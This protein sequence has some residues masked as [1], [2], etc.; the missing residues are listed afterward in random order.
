MVELDDIAGSPL[1]DAWLRIRSTEGKETLIAVEFKTE[2]SPKSA[3][4]ILRKLEGAKPRDLMLVAPHFTQRTQAY[5]RD[6]GIAFL[7]FSG[8]AYLKLDEPALFVSAVSNEPAPAPETGNRRLRGAKAGRLLRHI[9]DY[10]PPFSVSALARELSIDVGNVSR[11]LE[12]LNREAL[13][14]RGPRGV[15]TDVDW[16]GVLRRWSLDYRMPVQDRYHD[17]RGLDHF[18][19]ALQKTDARYVLS[20]VSA[21]SFYAPY[22]AETTALCYCDD[23]H[24]FAKALGL[25]TAERSSNVILALPF[26]KVVY[27]RTQVRSDLTLA[28]PSQVAVD[29][30]T[31]RGRDLQQAEELLRW[32]R[33]HESAWR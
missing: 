8:N 16:E 29:L 27:D 19:A 20:G 30:L 5:L 23:L 31:G 11:Y 3:E 24:S 32:M 17:P 9:C 12:L 18:R 2:F 4:T 1:Q 22:T 15:V 26:D 10:R 28:A 6:R 13:V 25:R 21:A 14:V 33:E 7:D